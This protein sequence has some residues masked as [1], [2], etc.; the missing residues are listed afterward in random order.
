MLNFTI[1]VDVSNAIEALAKKVAN[2]KDLRPAWEKAES[3]VIDAVRRN[4]LVGGRPSWPPT[5]GKKIDHRPLIGTGE[6]LARAT[7]PMMVSTPNGVVFVPRVGD[8]GAVHQF[9]FYGNVSVSE[10]FRNGRGEKKSSTV[11]AHIKRMKIPARPFFIIP[12]GTS[13]VSRITEFV[14]KRVMGD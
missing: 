1:S 7:R 9:G 12:H 4:F 13:D 6:L 10:H 14:R 11:R 8:A 2:I 5:K 3:V